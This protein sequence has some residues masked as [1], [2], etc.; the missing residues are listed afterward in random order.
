MRKRRTFFPIPNERALAVVPPAREEP[1][2]ATA[3]QL[4]LDALNASG[5]GEPIRLGLAWADLPLEDI[6]LFGVWPIFQRLAERL[7]RP[8]SGLAQATD[9]VAPRAQRLIDAGLLRT[10]ASATEAAQAF[11][12]T[13]LD[14]LETALQAAVRRGESPS[15]RALALPL[16]FTFFKK[17]FA[18]GKGLADEVETLARR[19]ERENFGEAE[20]FLVPLYLSSTTSSAP[21]RYLNALTGEADVPFPPST[22]GTPFDWV[23]AR[24]LLEDEPERLHRIRRLQVALRTLP[25]RLT[26][27]ADEAFEFRSAEHSLA[28]DWLNT[29]LLLAAAEREDAEYVWEHERDLLQEIAY[30]QSDEVLLDRLQKR[31]RARGWVP[32]P[33]HEA[34][35][36]AQVR[37]NMARHRANRGRPGF[38][39]WGAFTRLDVDA[40][41]RLHGATDLA[42]SPDRSDGRLRQAFDARGMSAADGIDW[43]TLEEAEVEQLILGKR[44]PLV[45]IVKR[46]PR[47]RPPVRRACLPQLREAVGRNRSAY[48]ALVRLG[49]VQLQVQEL[50]EAEAFLTRRTLLSAVR[51][52]LR[53]RAISGEDWVRLLLLLKRRGLRRSFRAMIAR[54][55]VRVEVVRLCTSTCLSDLDIDP[56]R[57]AKL[58]ALFGKVL[59]RRYVF[60]C[61]VATRFR[62]FT[63]PLRSRFL[64]KDDVYDYRRWP[65]LLFGDAES[66][67]A[68]VAYSHI[69][70]VAE[71]EFPR[72]LRVYT[73]RRSFA[74]LYADA[75]DLDAK[76]RAY[77]RG[78]KA[79]FRVL[80]ASKARFGLVRDREA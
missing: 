14:P 23:A 13:V 67:F 79:F 9:E 65:E 27:T 80:E 74:W 53:D 43:P 32:S 36:L 59:W 37:R 12:E 73:E 75:P 41:I 60:A 2:N 51:R 28:S 34:L 49:Y 44:L 30:A 68:C 69:L 31:L 7:G 63:A 1:S 38:R 48:S 6:V 62:T 18:A 26:F 39:F 8:L 64:P 46:F 47:L 33:A 20:V 22:D 45:E 58:R 16:S 19:I 72:L 61:E 42:T 50:I 66:S 17:V 5:E 10:Y 52:A 40:Y 70:G 4:F 54:P 24:R 76:W 3:F 71:A 15:F 56:S 57:A 25:T 11:R 21:L 29:Q 78:R 35:V 77:V 55:E